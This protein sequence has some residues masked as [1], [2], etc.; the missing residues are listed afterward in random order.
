ML[1]FVSE[2]YSPKRM[3]STADA[4]KK[5][6]LSVRIKIWPMCACVVYLQYALLKN[7]FKSL[8]TGTG[9]STHHPRIISNTITQLISFFSFI[10][11]FAA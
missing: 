5:E 10:N 6:N 2:I 11:L 4:R 7:S 8:S 1:L 9:S 3:R